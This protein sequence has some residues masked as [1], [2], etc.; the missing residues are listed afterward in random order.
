[1]SPEEGLGSKV[2]QGGSFPRG[3]FVIWMGF[4]DHSIDE[5]SCQYLWGAGQGLVNILQYRGQSASPARWRIAAAS[6]A[7]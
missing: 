6:P 2:S 1:M 5:E 7:A 4:F 3:S